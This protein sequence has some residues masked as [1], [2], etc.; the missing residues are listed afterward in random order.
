MMIRDNP[1]NHLLRL[2]KDGIKEAASRKYR[3]RCIFDNDD[4]PASKSK[5]AQCLII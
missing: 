2:E 1:C 5:F 4:P 3:D